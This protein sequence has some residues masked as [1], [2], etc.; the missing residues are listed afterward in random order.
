MSTENTSA[1]AP[2]PLRSVA[3]VGP[4][5]DAIKL[6]TS[7]RGTSANPFKR[8]ATLFDVAEPLLGVSLGGA[9][10]RNQIDYYYITKKE[11]VGHQHGM[12]YHVEHPTHA[13]QSR[14]VWEPRPDVGPGVFFGWLTDQAKAE[15]ALMD[16]T[17]SRV[18]A[19]QLVAEFEARY[20][21]AAKAPGG[22]NAA[23]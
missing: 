5:P 3:G 22:A 15:L 9:E 14:Y 18:S 7:W 4:Y 11:H 12:F 6:P 17:R 21:A 16:G 19:P 1:P 13:K 8:S 20:A 2:A 10:A 23:A